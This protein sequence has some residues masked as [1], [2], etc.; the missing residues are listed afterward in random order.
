M[1]PVR[2]PLFTLGDGQRGLPIFLANN[3]AG[4]AKDELLLALEKT[5]ILTKDEI[6]TAQ[7]ASKDFI[8]NHTGKS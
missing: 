4:N 6:E 2:V 8:E 7:K 3:F 5:N 1:G